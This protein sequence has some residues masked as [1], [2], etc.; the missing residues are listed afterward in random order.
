MSRQ[1][2]DI[3]NELDTRAPRAVQ[4][5]AEIVSE[6][7]RASAPV[8]TGGLSESVRPHA[9]KHNNAE[10]GWTCEVYPDGTNEEGERYALIGFVLEYGRSNMAARPWFRNTVEDVAGEVQD[11]M[12]SALQLGQ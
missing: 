12:A 6:A 9:V 4:A 10:D 8:R 7:L 3:A 2:A 5:G 11:A 1:L